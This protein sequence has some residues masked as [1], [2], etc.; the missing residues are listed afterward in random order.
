VKQID[1]YN[2]AKGEESVWDYPRP[3]ALE[4]EHQSVRIFKN[5]I[6][7]A[8]SNK[9]YRVLETSHPPVYYI[10]PEDIRMDLLKKTGRRSYCEWKGE[11]IYY[12]LHLND[13]V[14]ESVAWAYP[15]PTSRFA[16]IKDHLAF[17][18]AKM[19]RCY[20]GD[21][22]IQPQP[23]GFYGG[24]ISSKIKGPFKGAPGTYGW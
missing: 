10:S 6:R 7:I 14:I 15:N 11:A 22:L 9:V 12:D 20:L 23:G 8:D 13:Q 18:A 1:P 5:E 24:W 2:P 3:P 21:E 16:A 17:Y 4:K 19:D